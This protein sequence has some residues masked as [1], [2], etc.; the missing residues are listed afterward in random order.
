MD[1]KP[2]LVI[3]ACLAAGIGLRGAGTH[4]Y[5]TELYD[6]QH[7]SPLQQKFRRLAP[8]PIGVVFLPWAGCTEADVRMH[9][10]MMRQLGFNNLKQVMG[11]PDWPEH[12]LLRI[13]L[14]EDVIPFWYGEGGWDDITPALRARLGIPA[15]VPMTEVRRDPRMRAYQKQV[16]MRQLEAG[17]GR[18]E[19]LGKNFFGEP[20]PVL[21]EG[22]VALFRTWVRARYPVLEDLV[23]AWNLREVGI[24]RA[25]GPYV[26]WDD[27]ARDPLATPLARGDDPAPAPGREY[28]FVR[29]VLRFKADTNIEAI[30]RSRQPAIEGQPMRAGGEMGLFLPFASRGTDMEGIAQSMT[31]LGSFYPSLHL[32]WHFEEVDYEVT[33]SIYMMSSICVDWFKGGW[34]GIWE[35]TGGPQQFSGGKGWD[36]HGAAGTPGFTVNEGTIT[37]L[38]LSYL[39]GGAKGAGIWAWNPRHA[40]WESGEFAL[41]DR[42]MQPGARAIRAG[43]IAQAAERLRD[44]LWQAHKEPLVGVFINWDNEAIWAA[45]AGPGRTHFKHYPVQARVGISRALINA[46]VPWEHVTPSDLRAGLAARYRVIYL[47]AHVA[48]NEELFP[49]FDAF[50]R[51]GG[52]LVADAPVAW[53]NE[54]GR[55]LTTASGSPFERIFGSTIRDYQYSSNVPRQLGDHALQGFILELGPT[56]AA[57][58]ERFQTGEP[59]VTENRL[60]LGTAV[61][62]AADASFAMRRA[63]NEAME[64]WTLRHALGALRPNFACDGAI[65]YRLAAPAADHYFLMNDGP[66]TTARFDF[67]E[68]VYRSLS[69]VLTGEP[70][71]PG[72]VAVEAF[73]GR[74]L[75]AEK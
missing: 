27:F 74:W 37:Q 4:D 72:S 18:R 56:D 16:L 30:R 47:P 70:V 26:S 57:V 22:D 14:E 9:Y 1:M 44:E 48:I 5:L 45:V 61:L 17:R 75:R 62:L 54:R 50:V 43:R 58:V 31:D 73:G 49:L 19:D 59:A 38:L 10:R 32:A 24:S 2:L 64:R 68:L 13:A 39:A 33:R 12:E 7:D 21:R 52:R 66:A 51:Q 15:E 53:W 42:T 34:T 65:A 36:D 23:R 46:N 28:G 29:D 67:R 11:S 40:G 55:L 60:G 3:T 41:L 71:D 20:D 6:R 25:H 8:V 69:D 35:S 63:G